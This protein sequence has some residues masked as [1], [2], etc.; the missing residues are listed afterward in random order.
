MQSTCE[1]PMS[2]VPSRSRTV[3]CST[4]NP[5]PKKRIP[6]TSSSVWRTCVM[7]LSATVTLRPLAQMPVLSAPSET[8]PWITTLS[9]VEVIPGTRVAPSPE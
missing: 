4:L 8:N 9:A 3:L 6:S 7:T 2:E 5:S 1:S